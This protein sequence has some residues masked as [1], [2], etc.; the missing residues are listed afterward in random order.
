MWKIEGHER[1]MMNLRGGANLRLCRSHLARPFFVTTPI[2]ELNLSTMAK[3]RELSDLNT[4]EIN[5]F[6]QMIENFKQELSEED[7]DERSVISS[8]AH[9]ATKLQQVQVNPP[10]LTI[11]TSL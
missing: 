4:Q 5:L 6:L 8:L 9:V 10:L 7:D 3:K 2:T 1:I 11:N